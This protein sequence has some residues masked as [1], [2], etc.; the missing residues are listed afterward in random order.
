VSG[1]VGRDNGQFHLQFASELCADSAPERDLQ[2][3]QGLSENYSQKIC[4]P[5]M[6][7][8]ISVNDL[9]YVLVTLSGLSL[10][11]NVHK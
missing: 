9:S 8:Q 1:R 4:F 3:L 6:L 7:V 5:I 11:L 10:I 2:E